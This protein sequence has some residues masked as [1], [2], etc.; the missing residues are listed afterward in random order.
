MDSSKM[1]PE[2]NGLSLL[3]SSQAPMWP[4]MAADQN[5]SHFSLW[6]ELFGNPFLHLA[7]LVAR[8]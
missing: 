3:V 1:A 4:Y 8:C 2:F 5:P 6:P 7:Q